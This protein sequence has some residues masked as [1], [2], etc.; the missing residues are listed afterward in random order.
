MDLMGASRQVVEAVT[1]SPW[2]DQA[3]SLGSIPGASPTALEAA[4][5]GGGQF[6]ASPAPGSSG[7]QLPGV[8]WDLVLWLNSVGS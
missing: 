2:G 6:W 8:K 4:R 1:R 5:G 3:A 7:S